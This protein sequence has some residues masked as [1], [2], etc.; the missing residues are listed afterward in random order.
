[1]RAHDFVGTFGEYIV[2]P[3]SFGIADVDQS[4]LAVLPGQ[5]ALTVIIEEGI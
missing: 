3:Q 1:L 2:H 5:T 4:L